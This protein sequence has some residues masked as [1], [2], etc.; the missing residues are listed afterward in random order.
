[1][2]KTS[3]RSIP[4]SK[5]G[6]EKLREAKTSQ[7]LT[8]EKLAEKAGVSLS[9]VKRFFSGKAVDIPY[10]E[11]IAEALGL[12]LE[13]VIELSNNQPEITNS[14]S[15]QTILIHRQTCQQMLAEKRRL[16]TNPLTA[17]DGTTFDRLDLYVPL[18]LVERKRQSQRPDNVCAEG[19]SKLYQPTDYEI[20]Q[21][22]ENDE[23]FHRV[24][25]QGQS[26]KS[27]GKRIAVIGEPGSGK[28]T[29]LQ[30]IADRLFAE[31]EADVAIWVS[32]ADLQGKTIEEYLL[33]VWLKDAFST[34][35]VT[36]E[37]EDALV[38]LFNRGRVWL[39]L[40]GVDEMG[41][42]N[43]L[44]AIANQIRGWV[45]KAKVILTC[46]FNV[47]DGG[48]NA[49][50][51]FD[52][53]RNLDF[54]E[55]QV[56]EFIRRW[57]GSHPEL[58]EKLRSQ[59]TQPDKKRIRD[60]IKNPLRLALMCYFWQ[61]RQG[62]LPKTK[63][64]LYRRFIE[65]FYEWKEE[66]FPTTSAKRK[67]LNCALGKLAIE[68]LSR[69]DSRFR[70]TRRQVV[71]VLGETDGPLFQLATK[72]GWLNRVGVAAEDPD[73]P[74][75]AFFH[76]TFEEYFAA[77]A[78][79]DWDF[80]INHVWD[81]PNS[82]IYRIFEPQWREVILLWLGR[83]DIE[84]KQKDGFLNSLAEFEDNCGNFYRIKAYLLARD[85]L[86]ELR[87]C[88]DANFMNHILRKCGKYHR[89]A[90]NWR[91]TAYWR[92]G[93]LFSD[94][95]PCNPVEIPALIDR[96]AVTTDRKEITEIFR[97]IGASGVRSAKLINALVNLLENS[98][99]HNVIV[100]AMSL[101]KVV[102]AGDK[103]VIEAL[104]K[105]LPSKPDRDDWISCQAADTLL[106]IDPGNQ[107]AI[108]TL[109]NLL[110]KTKD[111]DAHTRLS[112]AW[113][114]AEIEPKNLLAIATLVNPIRQAKI[115]IYTRCGD[116]L[117]ALMHVA[118]GDL[119][120]LINLPEP[121]QVGVVILDDS[122]SDEGWVIVQ[123]IND[124]EDEYSLIEIDGFS[125]EKILTFSGEEAQFI[126]GI[127]AGDF[128][129]AVKA[130]NRYGS[131]HQEWEAKYWGYYKDWEEEDFPGEVPYWIYSNESFH[132]KTNPFF[133]DRPNGS[134]VYQ[135]A[136]NFLW[137]H[138]KK[139]SYLEFYRAWNG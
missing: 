58:G 7:R 128:L 4:A 98:K 45:A 115:N 62:N 77:A 139:M 124:N 73:E 66:F 76:P 71:L 97:K 55:G 33:Q 118:N 37:M 109:N 95:E 99:E 117:E 8:H 24:L 67:E 68:A 112:A 134:F 130:V 83:E 96:I 38:E 79:E 85:C 138:A 105:L 16:T 106:A 70:L 69:S 129:A 64:A 44:G 53:Y 61:R 35:R 110:T 133:L 93:Y 52:V 87:G 82:G 120:Y 10:A 103:K 54:S 21:Q 50:E 17:N 6:I 48:K 34:A 113:I 11:W 59:L 12:E 49:L 65:V 72:L 57:F 2:Q 88:R 75:Y 26:P 63:T 40:D 47:W 5:L 1:M 20:L 15:E 56:T 30:Q 80:F 14:R 119:L 41:A 111:E 81:N 86:C 100:E 92:Q 84:D 122:F 9:T 90:D 13:E 123:T 116:S 39:L 121:Y 51:G 94:R 102:G 25:L 135:L 36:P 104:T 42:D 46:R 78:I 28:T 3:S 32:L 107:Q 101:L 136:E 31:T 43:P 137:S 131:E 74:V 125:S 22:F 18:G 132:R 91:P 29:L 126:K 114:L 19:G 60:T 89:F 27:Q 127:F 108:S 23:F